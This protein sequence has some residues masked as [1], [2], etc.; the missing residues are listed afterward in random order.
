LKLD[1]LIR[2]VR[3][4]RIQLLNLEDLSDEE[5]RMLQ[6]QFQRLRK[7]AEHDGNQRAH[8]APAVTQ[9]KSP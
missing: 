5:L 1:E 9:R 7:K 8:R 2:A 4:A 3:S 6:E